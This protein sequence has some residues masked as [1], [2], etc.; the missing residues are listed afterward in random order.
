[1]AADYDPIRAIE[2]KLSDLELKHSDIR[3]D[4]RS[5]REDVERLK[6]D[7]PTYVTHERFHPVERITLGLVGTVL[8]TVVAAVLALVL[9]TQ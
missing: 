2:H 6:A 7:A 3:S 9:R 5:I 8:L 4:V 1:M